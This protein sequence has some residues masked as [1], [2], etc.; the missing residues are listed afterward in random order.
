[1]PIFDLKTME[2]DAGE[3]ATDKQVNAAFNKYW[4]SSM[5]VK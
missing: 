4:A 2:A 1:M 3:I 5:A